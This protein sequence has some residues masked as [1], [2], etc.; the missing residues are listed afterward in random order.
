MDPEQKEKNILKYI[1]WDMK[2]KHT[3]SCGIK[4]NQ[5]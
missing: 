1:S 4:Q 2:M 5:L 3:T